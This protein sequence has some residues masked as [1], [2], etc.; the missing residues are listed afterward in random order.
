MNGTQVVKA[1]PLTM[2]SLINQMLAN[3]NTTLRAK[4]AASESAY[5]RLQTAH[6]QLKGR[7]AALEVTLDRSEEV[8]RSHW[9]Q[10]KGLRL[11]VEQLKQTIATN[12]AGIKRLGCENFALRAEKEYAEIELKGATD[13]IAML[14]RQL[15]AADAENLELRAAL[16]VAKLPEGSRDNVIQLVREAVA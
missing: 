1:S 9:S 6:S 11:E 15:A 13:R 2:V 4:L 14:E 16:V 12:E 3:E 10:V 7:A 8:T 5:E